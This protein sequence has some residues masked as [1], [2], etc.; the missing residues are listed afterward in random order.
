ML[1]NTQE[2]L[3]TSVLTDRDAL[4]ASLDEKGLL[5]EQIR[6]VV[7]NEY[8]AEYMPIMRDVIRLRRAR[9]IEIAQRKPRTRNGPYDTA[10][11]GKARERAKVA[12]EQNK[13][14]TKGCVKRGEANVRPATTPQVALNSSASE[15]LYV[16]VPRRHL[17][18]N[19]IAAKIAK[20]ESDKKKSK[21]LRVSQYLRLLCDKFAPHIQAMLSYDQIECVIPGVKRFSKMGCIV[22]QVGGLYR[23]HTKLSVEGKLKNVVA[24]RF[25]TC[26]GYHEGHTDGKTLT[27][28]PHWLSDS[29]YKL[30]IN[31]IRKYRVDIASQVDAPDEERFDC[32][33][34]SNETF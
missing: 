14:K 19:F 10:S 21:S 25:K 32:E 3:D 20:E 6:E 13:G 30:I 11:R 9:G 15:Q 23:R 29:D 24:A 28:C 7:K 17:N 16:D 18:L 2:T 22:R 33:E 1:G 12:R 4:I 26:A 5:I 34:V 8:G 31:E 27:P